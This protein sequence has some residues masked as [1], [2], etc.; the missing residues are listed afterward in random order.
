LFMGTS[1]ASPHVAGV[2]A[3]LYGAGV[4]DPAAIERILKQTARKPASYRGRH[5]EHYGA[6]IVDAAAA[7]KEAQAG[8]GATQLGV[9]GGLGLLL[10]ALL[11][12][13][14]RMGV[15]GWLVA[16]AVGGGLF[17]LPALTG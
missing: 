12:R 11:G 13:R 9:T 7:V 3:L 14:F 1:M 16:G 15:S 4:T 5:D 17:F 6:G 10:L 8:R 2:A